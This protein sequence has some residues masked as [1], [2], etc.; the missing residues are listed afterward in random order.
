[1]G[2][3]MKSFAVTVPAEASYLKVIRGF[4]QPVLEQVVGERACMLI[5]ALDEACSN[6]IKYRA[7]SLERCLIH[8]RAQ[9]CEERATFRIGDF[10][11]SADVSRINPRSLDD[12]RPG[13]L[14]THFINEIMDEVSFEPE[15][16]NPERMALV[17]TKRLPLKEVDNATEN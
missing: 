17:L 11:D 10:C 15:P 12:I 14:G 6:I 3:D 2:S 8:V 5:L 7:N 1:M 16:E 13:G 4:F 9:I